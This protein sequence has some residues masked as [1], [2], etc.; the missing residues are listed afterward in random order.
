MSFS[1]QRTPINEKKMSNKLKVFTSNFWVLTGDSIHIDN[2]W[3]ATATMFDW[4]SGNGTYR[5]PYLI[6]NV[7]INCLGSSYGIEII[8]SSEFFII[9]NC[10]ILNSSLEGFGISLTHVNNSKIIAN[11]CSFNGGG[12]ALGGCYNNSISNNILIN[13]SGGIWMISSYNNTIS[14][15]NIDKNIYGA[16]SI[17]FSKFN[18]IIRNNMS[19]QY[20]YGMHLMVSDV[21]IISNNRINNNNMGGLYL[22]SC[23][24]NTIKRNVISYNIGDGILIEDSDNN[25][26]SR[27]TCC[28][29]SKSGIHI[30]TFIYWE[31]MRG[32]YNIISQNDASYNSYGIKLKY[33]D[34]TNILNNILNY[35]T[36]FGIFLNL[37]DYNVVTGNTINNNRHGVNV[38]NSINNNFLT[39]KLNNNYYGI[40]FID[41]H[42]N[43]V[44]HNTILNSIKCFVEEGQCIDNTFENNTCQEQPILNEWIILG[45]VLF[46]SGVGLIGFFLIINRRKRQ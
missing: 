23:D 16:I 31:G 6:E 34:H 32:I 7:T 35:N 13:N 41:S 15:N 9:R 21:N 29:N 40:Y 3:T 39:N 44:N 20:L 2:N 8:N 46:I 10:T 24:D 17:Y 12:I 36:N 42:K 1:F 27:N 18:K 33:S 25:N 30:K 26:I 5:N 11:N 4:C 28:Y 38:L 19:H 22:D 45:I 37:S 43:T 14:D